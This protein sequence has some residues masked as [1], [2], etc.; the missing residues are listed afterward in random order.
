MNFIITPKCNK[1][2]SF[3]FAR[4]WR[5]SCKQDMSWDTFKTLVEKTEIVKLLGGEPTLHP[6]FIDFVQYA[7]KKKKIITIVTNLLINNDKIIDFLVRTV[8]KYPIGFLLNGS[9][10]YG[11]RLELF[12]KNYNAIY[13]TAYRVDNEMNMRL[14][15][16]IPKGA[17][18]DIPKYIDYL[19]SLTDKLIN[20]D[21]LRLSL[22]FPGEDK[23][24]GDYYFLNNKK[25]GNLFLAVTQFAVQNGIKPTIDCIIFPC[26]FSNKEE[27]KYMIKFNTKVLTMCGNS[28][29]PLDVFPNGK[30]VYGFPLRKVAEIDTSEYDNVKQMIKALVSKYQ[31]VNSIAE[32]PE[33]CK[34][35][36]FYHK[37]CEGPCLGFKPRPLEF[38]I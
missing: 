1:N 2:C 28:S 24:K 25:L 21:T 5:E 18:N 4:K 11:K 16:T 19:K 12:S 29:M 17:E 34:K 35:C 13:K 23:L 33:A 26:M 14:G 30:A 22:T 37:I 20:I 10:L 8:Q 31:I 7:I 9:E 38:K 36:N 32:T 3:C 6:N 27:F 15:V